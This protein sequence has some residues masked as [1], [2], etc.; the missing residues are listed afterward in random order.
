MNLKDDSSGWESLDNANIDN[1]QTTLK[2]DKF[3]SEAALNA[4]QN[5]QVVNNNA[6]N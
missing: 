4:M 2:S 5:A 3:I 1:I 6:V